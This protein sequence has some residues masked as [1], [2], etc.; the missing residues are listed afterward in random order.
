VLPAFYWD[1]SEAMS[2]DDAGGEVSGGW[3]WLDSRHQP[4]ERGSRSSALHPS[5]K[6]ISLSRI[7]GLIEMEL[8]GDRIPRIDE[9]R[10]FTFR[11][12]FRYQLSLGEKSV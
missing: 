9:P 3:T 6:P 10:M 11:L 4:E 1:V 7:T 2:A 8:S 12:P 5:A